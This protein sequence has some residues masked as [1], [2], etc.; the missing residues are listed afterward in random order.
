MPSLVLWIVF[1][2]KHGMAR[3]LINVRLSRPAAAALSRLGPAATGRAVVVV[4]VVAAGPLPHTPFRARRLS[5]RTAL[6]AALARLVVLAGAEDAVLVSLAAGGRATRGGSAG[7]AVAPLVVQQAPAL[8]TPGFAVSGATRDGKGQKGRHKDDEA[9]GHKDVCQQAGEFGLLG[10]QSTRC[11]DLDR[12][13][14]GFQ[15]LSVHLVSDRD[16][17]NGS[18]GVS[19]RDAVRL[20]GEGIVRVKLPALVDQVVV[21]HSGVANH[22]SIL[23]GGIV[24][25]A[26]AIHVLLVDFVELREGV[27]LGVVPPVVGPAVRV[28][29][30]SILASEVDV[31][32]QPEI[33]V[34]HSAR[35][36]SDETLGIRVE[37]HLVSSEGLGGHTGVQKGS[38]AIVANVEAIVI[39]HVGQTG[40][41]HDVFVFINRPQVLGDLFY[42]LIEFLSVD[43][44]QNP[45]RVGF[46]AIQYAHWFIAKVFV[47]SVSLVVWIDVRSPHHPSRTSC[48]VSVSASS[49]V[50]TSFRFLVIAVDK[51]TEHSIGLLPHVVIVTRIGVIQHVAVASSRSSPEFSEFVGVVLCEFLDLLVGK[52]FHLVGIGAD[53]LHGV[54]NLGPAL[55]VPLQACLP[56]GF[57]FLRGGCLRIGALRYLE[58]LFLCR[59]R[60][61]RPRVVFRFVLGPTFRGPKQGF[62]G[63]EFGL[64]RSGA[65]ASGAHSVCQKQGPEKQDIFHGVFV[66]LR[67]CVCVCVCYRFDSIR[68]DSIVLY[69][70]RSC[71]CRWCCCNGTQCDRSKRYV[72]TETKQCSSWYPS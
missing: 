30:G 55:A 44:Q 24:D 37:S 68:F 11:F 31:V 48:V 33:V 71:C 54:R 41:C 4:S 26:R 63:I 14:E 15:G 67:V 60:R 62:D 43:S 72:E 61:P 59:R 29:I 64:S 2:A 16:A 50:T 10:H 7:S 32:L 65:G 9:K 70:C 34:G 27:L 45:F 49:L 1:L 35:F 19:Q 51:R 38:A 23:V 20:A 28:V 66:C 5:P 22:V 56:L 18:L 69:W 52:L 3:F 17:Q 13:V 40:E 57:S 58:R 25:A 6:G 47:V 8:G 42:E 53:L 36:V 21:V 12:A 39:G 46:V